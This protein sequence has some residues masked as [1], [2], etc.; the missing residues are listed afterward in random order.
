MLGFNSWVGW[1]P[2]SCLLDVDLLPLG[3]SHCATKP[4][5]VTACQEQF[6]CI[7]LV[8]TPLVCL[9]FGQTE[10]LGIKPWPCVASPAATSSMRPLPKNLPPS[11]VTVDQGWYFWEC[12]NRNF[13]LVCERN[14]G[15]A[16][17]S[18]GMIMEKPAGDV[19]V[20]KRNCSWNSER[21]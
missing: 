10:E 20:G 15:S 16:A 17:A 13:F 12:P 19:N 11:L 7:F 1:V 14:L 2:S 3:F 5:N 21:G 18:S 4:I 8:F 9:D 6:K